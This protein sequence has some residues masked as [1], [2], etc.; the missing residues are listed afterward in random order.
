MPIQKPWDK[1]EAAILLVNYLKTLN[2]ELSRKEA[3]ENTSSQLRVLGKIRQ[4]N[5]DSVFRNVNGITFQMH[6]MESAYKGITLLK[7][8]SKLFLETAGLFKNNKKQFEDILKEVEAMMAAS[9]K[10]NRESYIAWLSK[11]VSPTQLSELYM[12]L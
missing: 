11:K 1:Y 9:T 7:P 10:D 6:S 2:G 3:I 12:V 5:V 8:A 4:N